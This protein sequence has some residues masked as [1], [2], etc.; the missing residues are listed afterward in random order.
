M[1]KIYK[2]I[3]ILILLVIT[4]LGL[5]YLGVY[6]IGTSNHDN[7]MVNWILDTGMTQAVQYHAKK[8]QVPPLSDPALVQ[9]G[10]RHYN[11]M[12]VS[13]HGA[14][15]VLP[16]EIAQGLWPAA[17]DLTKTATDWTPAQLYW[18]VKNG[19]KFTAMPAW[20]PSHTDQEIWA[21]VAFLQKFPSLSAQDYKA[22]KT[23]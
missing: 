22:M 14:P 10:F 8:I 7:A 9:T 16:G 13:C 1:T 17:P 21:M 20:G 12:C 6:D 4:G 3:L 11:E 23:R 5:I 2:G 19:I 15:G 18:I